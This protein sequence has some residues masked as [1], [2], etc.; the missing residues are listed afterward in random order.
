MQ[1]AVH[2][3]ALLMAAHEKLAEGF[4]AAIQ[5]Q[6]QKARIRVPSSEFPKMVAS[7][8]RCL[9]HKF[10]LHHGHPNQLTALA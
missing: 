10:A 6:I 1:L 9:V 8:T 4:S 2:T 3:R 7:K 5:V